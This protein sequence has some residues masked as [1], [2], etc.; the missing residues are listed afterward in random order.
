MIN[1]A[2]KAGIPPSQLQLCLEPEAAAIATIHDSSVT[3]LIAKGTRYMVL[4]VGGGTC[5]ITCHEVTCP[6]RFE[7]KEIRK[8]NGGDCGSCQINARFEQILAE[9]ITGGK[10]SWR[11]FKMK[12]PRAYNEFCENFEQCKLEFSSKE[13]LYIPIPSSL[14][15]LLPKDYRDGMEIDEDYLILDREFVSKL[16]DDASIL[17]ITNLLAWE[18]NSCD[19]RGLDFV[20]LA[21]GFANSIYLR[22]KVQDCVSKISSTIEVKYPL[23][24][25]MAILKGGAMMGESPTAIISR[26]ARFTYAV[27][28]VEDFDVSRGHDERRSYVT[29]EGLKKIRVLRILVNEGEDVRLGQEISSKISNPEPTSR[30]VDDIYRCIGTDIRY[31]DEKDAQKLGQLRIKLGRCHATHCANVK[32]IYKF[33][34]THLSIEALDEETDKLFALNLEFY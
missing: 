3:A 27:T 13:E 29:S 4:D 22:R 6:E 30:L 5:D 20:F 32:V 23:D 12:S 25:S 17:K 18:L 21:G 1:A 2:I 11:T 8:V 16:F 28:R 15:K 26:K 31:P 19:G 7:V 33:G 9:R 14:A 10:K 24:A 34:G